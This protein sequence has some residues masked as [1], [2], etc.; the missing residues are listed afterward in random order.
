MK[1]AG[2]QD[3]GLGPIVAFKFT[4]GLLLLACALVVIRLLHQD[5]AAVAY[6]WITLLHVNPHNRLMH[7][8]LLELRALNDRR[9]LEIGTGA[10][11]YAGLLLTEGAGLFLRKRWAEYLT[12]AA[13]AS[14]IPLEFYDFLRYPLWA[15]LGLIA[16][17]LLVAGYLVAWVRKSPRFAPLVVRLSSAGAAWKL[18]RN[19]CAAPVRV[20]STPHS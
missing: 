8:L 16:A 18:L 2:S 17:N 11:L 12:I 9:L 5:A 14:L 20:A 1:S 3:A 13:T 4:K 6:R 10:F 15:R 19:A 7:A